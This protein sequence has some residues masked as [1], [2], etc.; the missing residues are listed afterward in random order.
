MLYPSFQACGT[1]MHSQHGHTQNLAL[2]GP[3]MCAKRTEVSNL[4]TEN[5]TGKIEVCLNSTQVTDS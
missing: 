2:F 4:R 3:Q 5:Y 1:V